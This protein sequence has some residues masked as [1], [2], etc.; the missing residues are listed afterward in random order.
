MWDYYQGPVGHGRYLST[1][2]VDA[3][4]HESVFEA[5][6]A[7]CGGELL[8]ERSL[9]QRAALQVFLEHKKRRTRR[10]SHVM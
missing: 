6:G 10:L 8:R 4:L 1:L 5:V 3:A 9:M 2:H 7:D